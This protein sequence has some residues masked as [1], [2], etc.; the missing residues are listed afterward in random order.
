[1]VIKWF[2]TTILQTIFF[3]VMQ[4]QKKNHTGFKQHNGE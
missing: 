4:K 1:M 2:V 3:Y